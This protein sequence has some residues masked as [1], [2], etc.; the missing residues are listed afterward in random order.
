L[1][2]SENKALTWGFGGVLGRTRTPNLLIPQTH[3]SVATEHA[4][5]CTVRTAHVGR[6]LS[7]AVMGYPPPYP[8]DWD[9]ASAVVLA[10]EARYLAAADL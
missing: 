7:F 9:R 8:D 4:P 2:N 5:Y 6:A 1:P 3:R 10:D